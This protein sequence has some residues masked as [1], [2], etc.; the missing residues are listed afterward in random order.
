MNMPAERS[1]VS[2][3]LLTVLHCAFVGCSSEDE[4]LDLTADQLLTEI[5]RMRA[6]IGPMPAN[7]ADAALHALTSKDAR[8]RA[9]AAV[10]VGKSQ[11]VP[12]SVIMQLENLGVSDADPVARGAA[13]TALYELGHP[14]Q[15]IEKL[16]EGLREDPQ[17]GSLATRLCASE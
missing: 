12:R 9:E 6:S 14:T 3:F 1:V 11:G 17:L 5:D 10:S 7:S 4:R 2:V 13:L 15:R 8:V 16:T